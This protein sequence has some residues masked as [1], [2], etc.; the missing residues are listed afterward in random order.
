M[1]GADLGACGEVVDFNGV[2][3]A[4]RDGGGAGN[5]GAFDSGEVGRE[6]K[7]GN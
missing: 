1:E 7:E 5:V 6:G 3:G 2:I 4:T